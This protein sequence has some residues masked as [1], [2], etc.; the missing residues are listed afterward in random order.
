MLTLTLRRLIAKT[1]IAA[2][3]FTQLAVAAYGCPVSAPNESKPA[4]MADDI[5]AAMPECEKHDGSNSN[6]CLQHCQAGSQSVQTTPQLNV[7]AFAL[8]PVIVMAPVQPVSNLGITVPSAL[9][10]RETSPPLLIRFCSFL[11]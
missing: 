3:L 6:L 7:P 8:I 5:H 9:L 2:L 1:G 4:A 10:T 11:I